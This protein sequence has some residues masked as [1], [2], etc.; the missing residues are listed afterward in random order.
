MTAFSTD[1]RSSIGACPPLEDIAAFLDGTLSPEDRKRITAHL[2]SCESCYEIFIGA[3]HFQED[4]GSA[5]DTDGDVVP[6]PFG[7]ETNRTSVSLPVATAKEEVRPRASRWLALA[8]SIL[9]VTALGFLAWREFVAPPRIV[10]ADVAEPLEQNASI[11]DL[12]YEGETPRG[13]PTPGDLSARPSFMTGVYLLDL[14]LS[15]QAGDLDRTRGLLQDLSL[16][17]KEI[18]FLPDGMAE[19]YKK[20][21]LRMETTADLAR[22]APQLPAKETQ[23]QEALSAYEAFPFGLWAEA[24]RLSALTPSSEFFESRK[25]RRF[26]SHLLEEE[27]LPVPAELHEPVL[28]HLQAVESIWDG[29]EKDYHAIAGHLQLIIKAIDEYEEDY[30]YEN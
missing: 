23:I 19:S 27:E 17:L 21:Y 7:G 20:E 26:L 15:L 18:P 9:I 29:E 8:A 6:F 5:S 11:S 3:V 13:G 30:S 25:N 14:R 24:G 10:L 2:A 12:L 4:E 1:T 22:L 16:S 28:D